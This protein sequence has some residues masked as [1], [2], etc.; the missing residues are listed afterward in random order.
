MSLSPRQMNAYLE[1]IDKIDNLER[2]AALMVGA[3]AAQGDKD[4]IEKTHKQLTEQWR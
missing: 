2:A 3:V 4:L 1:F